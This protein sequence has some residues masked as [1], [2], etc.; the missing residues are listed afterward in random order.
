M[1]TATAPPPTAPGYVKAA[2]IARI[3]N[4]TKECVFRWAKDGKIPSLR[5]AGT[6]RFDETAVREAIEGEVV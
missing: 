2:D 1:K 3:Y 5:F 6:V 4:V